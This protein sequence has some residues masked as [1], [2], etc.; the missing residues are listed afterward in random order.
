MF[1]LTD[2]NELKNYD[3]VEDLAQEASEKYENTGQMVQ[4]H[5]LG[6]GDDVEEDLLI[7]IASRTRGTN[8]MVEDVYSEQV[9]EEVMNALQ[10]AM[11]PNG[12]NRFSVQWLCKGKAPEE[13]EKE[14]IKVNELQVFYKVM[15]RSELEQ[16][17]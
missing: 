14:D 1:F 3:E 17:C 11:L 9:D 15:S 5:T 4:I 13:H 16:E 7:S 10:L 6:I 2:G 12:L 8:S